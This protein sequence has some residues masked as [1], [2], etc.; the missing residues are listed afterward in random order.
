MQVARQKINV[1][2]LVEEQWFKSGLVGLFDT[3]MGLA[4]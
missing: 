4:N 3:E 1:S 2:N